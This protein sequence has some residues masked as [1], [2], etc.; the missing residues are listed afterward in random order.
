MTLDVDITHRLG[1]FALDARFQARGG[2]T[3]L[4]GRSG[5]G[6]TTLINIIG[7]LVRPDRGRVAINGTTVVD[8]GARVFAPPHRR[9]AG[10]VFQDGRLFPHLSVK[11]NL[12]YGRWFAG[13]RLDQGELDR[14]VAL[15][16][17]GPVMDRRPRTLSGGERQRVAIGRAL[18]ARPRV[19]LMDEPLAS[20]D[21]PRRQEILPV[22]ER[23]RDQA[24]VPIVYV[25]HSLAEVARLAT[26]VVVLEAGRVA[27]SGPAQ[28][29]IARLDLAPAVDP[30][31]AGALIEAVVDRHDDAFALTVLRSRAGLWRVPRA[32]ANVG[33]RVR[34]RVRARDVVLCR[35]APEATSAL[36]AFSGV[37][38]ELGADGATEA[39]V[40]LDCQGDLLVVRLTRYSVER[41]G[42]EPG[43]R[44]CA[45]I[46]A[47][48][49]EPPAVA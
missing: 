29:V 21:E 45:I 27:A 49:L 39:H 15:L 6:K 31:E 46:K 10:Y 5:A 19:L 38:T 42:I 11:Q 26:T 18:L 17:L 7:G 25:S 44:L 40:R 24:G 32:G 12:L 3:A 1:A 22:I 41:M 23:L 4:F 30:A 35:A 36:N 43:A 34:L 8:T 28:D 14:L 33:D 16:G 47:V 20:L 37:V 2:V 13:G 9:G 48:A